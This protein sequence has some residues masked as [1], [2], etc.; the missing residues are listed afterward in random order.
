[1]RVE[2]LERYEEFKDAARK[3]KDKLEN[4]RKFQQFKRDADEL[5]AWVNEKTRIASDESYKDR[6]NLQAKIQ[7][8]QAFEAEV[9][10]HEN[11]IAS[12]QNTGKA[13]ISYNHF[14]REAIQ[15][16]LDEISS[17]WRS[18]LEISGDKRQKLQD[19]QK[20]EEFM[21]EADEVAA[22]ISDR[23]A[24]ASSDEMGKDLEYVEMLQ[25]NFDDFLKDL[26]AN[27]ARISSI[28]KL[29]EQLVEENHPDTELIRTR[30]EALN[31]AWKDLRGLA[32]LRHEKLM[33]AH[34]IQKF[35]RETDETKSWMNE[36]DTA[37]MSD[38]Y[39]RDLASVQALQRRHEGLERELAALQDKVTLLGEEAMNL[40]KNHPESTDQIA[41]KQAEIVG[42]WE[43]V[44]HKA[45]KRG[46]RLDD[47]LKFQKFLA[48]QRELLSWVSDMKALI[49]ADELAKDVAGAEALQQRHRERKGE[50]DAQEDNFK[51]TAQFG[52]GLI[53]SGHYA[54]EEVKEC[55]QALSNGRS[56][57]VGSWEG[58]KAE[59]EQ[60][61]EFQ[62]FMR[63][64]EQTN[65][66]VTKQE[67]VLAM[68]DIGDSLDTT[69][70]LLKKQEDF[71]KTMAAQEEKFKALDEAAARLI[72]AGNYAKEEV[73]A[74]RL[75]I[76]ASR[77][78][79]TVHMQKRRADL[80]EAHLL[81]QFLR[82]AEEARGWIAEKMKVAG[83]EAYKDPTNLEG[84][85]QQQQAFEGE[86]LANKGRIDAVIESAREL[87]QSGHHSPEV[88]GT[89]AK[90]IED[91]WAELGVLSG[92][93]GRKLK[94]ASEQQ[95][96]Y[97][98]VKDLDLWLDEVE[99]QLGSED[100]GKDMSGVQ[101]LQKKLNLLET[102]ITV[103]QDQIDTLDRQ[104]NQFMEENHFD[105]G[106]IQMRQR[107]LGARYEALEIPLKSLKAKLEA[108]YQLQKFFRDVEDEETWVKEKEPLAAS[109]NR[110]KDLIGVQNLIKKHQ[111]LMSEISSHESFITTVCADGDSMISQGHFGA[112]EIKKKTLM[113]SDKWEQLKE[114]VQERKKDLENAL[115]VHQYYADANEAESWMKEKE[116][117][118]SS[119]DYGKD[120]DSAEALLKKHETVLTDIEAFSTT[121]S[122]LAES[123]KSSESSDSQ[124]PPPPPPSSQ[125]QQ[126]QVKVLYYTYTART[127]RELSVQKGDILTLLNS[128]NNVCLGN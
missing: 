16:R 75:E 72:Q 114:R 37:L 128:A 98:T 68:E 43:G 14:A 82:D 73:D 122:S 118:V 59:F 78:N 1:M 123:C 89:K 7:K 97:R 101:L 88:I 96:Y 105:S 56:S 19:A 10:A 48:D 5:E 86:L 25:K 126:A 113:L 53:S 29:A 77:N 120:E 4:A 90:E 51:M 11:S 104:A 31:Q 79:L 55:L 17:L 70:A 115:Q 100:L 49:S 13:M 8:H 111:A 67:A 103:H 38:D 119:G 106:A 27:E 102:D 46:T 3:R 57:L 47:A 21:R 74:R 62:V 80:E 58:R 34:E 116:A 12:F 54:S 124:P 85:V 18:L 9:A 61:M 69:E 121:I 33:G 32:Q 107:E 20:R 95:K 41:A 84:K 127:P 39:G 50:I 64:T 28:N 24:V 36:K 6:A 92:D 52:Q 108:S 65:N 35:N 91:L 63:D 40:Q 81:Q 26:Q 112:T 117:V 87:V 15:A 22:W 2:V 71:E 66:W 23:K 45:S 30:Q 60:C 76:L 44:K 125:P 93:K 83:D 42:L 109:K 94:Q 110:G 99:K